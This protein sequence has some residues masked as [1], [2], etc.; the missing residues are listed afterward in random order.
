MTTIND[1]NAAQSAYYRQ[2]DP[3]E[4][5]MP[6]WEDYTEAEQREHANG[7]DG[8][9]LCEAHRDWGV[10]PACQH[11]MAEAIDGKTLCCG[12]VALFGE[13]ADGWWAA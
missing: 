4:P 13:Q 1:Y 2:H 10:C 9:A 7:C 6:E 12:A 8:C 11:G 5:A 3:S